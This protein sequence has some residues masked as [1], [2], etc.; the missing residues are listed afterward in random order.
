MAIERYVISAPARGTDLESDDN[1]APVIFQVVETSAPD[2]KER[3]YESIR[4][5]C[6][7]GPAPSVY[8]WDAWLEE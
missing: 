8:S 3:N 5:L 4:W 2:V 6:R 1:S 7:R